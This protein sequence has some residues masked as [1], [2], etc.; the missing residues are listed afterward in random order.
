MVPI[1]RRAS[2]PSASSA[3]PPWRI[4][5]VTGFKNYVRLQYVMF[6]ATGILVVIL[7][8]QFLRTDPAPFA[9]SMNHFSNVVD[10]REGYY[11]WLLEGRL[12]APAS[13]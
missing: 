12:R 11:Q 8:V 13:T 7:M 4:L 10:G 2:S 3:P 6:A 1:G 5:L 9:V